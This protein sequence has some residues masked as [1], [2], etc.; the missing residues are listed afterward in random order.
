[1]ARGIQVLFSPGLDKGIDNRHKHH[2]GYICQKQPLAQGRVRQK[3]HYH[4]HQA[5]GYPDISSQ[6][7]CFAPYGFALQ[8]PGSPD[9]DKIVGSDGLEVI[10]QGYKQGS[11]Q[12]AQ[13]VDLESILMS[14]VVNEKDGSSIVF[15]SGNYEFSL[16]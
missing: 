6:P 16:T 15:G 4:Y 13:D 5:S 9:A 12:Q 8:R 3:C 14:S 11:K 2:H 10:A 7:V 1:M